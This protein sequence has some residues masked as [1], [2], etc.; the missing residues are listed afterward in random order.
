MV[1]GKRNIGASYR[2]W[3]FFIDAQARAAGDCV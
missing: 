2:F 3:A 1:K